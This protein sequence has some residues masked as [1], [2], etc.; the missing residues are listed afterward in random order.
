MQPEKGT[1]NK[2]TNATKFNEEVVKEM[3]AAGFKNVRNESC[4][5]F[6]LYL[7]VIR[8]ISTVK[9]LGAKYFEENTTCGPKLKEIIYKFSNQ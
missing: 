4:S 7:M 9:G 6:G 1:K 3:E 5:E 2:M 8:G